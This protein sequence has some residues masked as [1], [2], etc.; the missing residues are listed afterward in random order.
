MKLTFNLPIKKEGIINENKN[1]LLN[2]SMTRNDSISS[3]FESSKNLFFPSSHNLQ[4]ISGNI[5]INNNINQKESNVN[6]INE[7][8][9]IKKKTEVSNVSRTFNYHFND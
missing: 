7:S 2:D 6:N 8:R 4:T 9:G 1:A 3:S 5:N